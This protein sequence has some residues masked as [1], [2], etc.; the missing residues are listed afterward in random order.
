MHTQICMTNAAVASHQVRFRP[1]KA[2]LERLFCHVSNWHKQRRVIRQLQ[3]LDDH[4]LKDIGVH[5][6]EITSVVN[7]RYTDPFRLRRT[8]G[9][10]GSPTRTER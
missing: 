1:F 5:R 10:A 8:D 3:E 7:R 9:Q 2:F 6:S 4:V